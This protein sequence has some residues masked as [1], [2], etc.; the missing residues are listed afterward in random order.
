M[1]ERCNVLLRKLAVVQ[2]IVPTPNEHNQHFEVRIFIKFACDL[3]W[4]V[5]FI[6]DDLSLFKIY[7]SS[8]C[9]SVTRF[10]NTNVQ[11]QFADM[12]ITHHIFSWILFDFFG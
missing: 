12:Q 5:D 1:N 9:K 6:V 4:H 11:A 3:K 8:S 7:L 10:T 2:S